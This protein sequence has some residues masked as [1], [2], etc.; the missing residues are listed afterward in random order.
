MPNIG[1]VLKDEISRLC[2]REVRKQVQPVRKAS[3]GYRHDIA[4]LKRQVQDLQRRNAEL[5][6]RAVSA[7]ASS[8]EASAAPASRFVAKGLRSLRKR[9]GLSAPELARLMSVSDQSIYNWEL[10]KSTPRKAQLA[11]LATIRAMGKREAR[12]RLQALQEQPKTRR[13]R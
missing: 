6:K 2:R 1:A 13:K 11:T 5:A 12:A 9:L 3:A 10:K 4:A 7:K 8:E